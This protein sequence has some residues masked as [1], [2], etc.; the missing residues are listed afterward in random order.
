VI[1]CEDCGFEV[2]TV[3]GTPYCS[4]Y[5]AVMPTEDIKKYRDPEPG[6]WG[7]YPCRN[8][9]QPTEGEAHGHSDPP[10]ICSECGPQ[11]RLKRRTE[12]LERVLPI[13]RETSTNL[14]NSSLVVEIEKELG[15]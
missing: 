14:T 4:E 2:R 7:I 12:L 13:L 9:G 10:F 11:L 5:C 3:D 6:L 1:T 15:S 8:C